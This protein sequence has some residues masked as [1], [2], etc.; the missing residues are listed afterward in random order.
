MQIPPFTIT[1]TILNLMVKISEKIGQLQ[2]AYVQ[3][4]HLR[5]NN[6]LRSIQASLAIENNS[7]SL[8]QVTDIINGRKVLGKPKEIQ[9]VKNAFDAYEI[10]PHLSPYRVED[11][12]QSHHLMMQGLVD[13]AGQFRTGDVGIF[14][15]QGK[16]MHL[17]ARP[18]FVPRLIADLFAWAEQ[19]STPA[20]IKSCVM[21]YEIEVI[22]PF[23]DGNGRMGRLWQTLVLSADTPVFAWLPIETMVYQHQADYY[24]TLAQADT[25]N[26][27][28][29][30][31]E[32]Y[33]V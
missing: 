1:N 32:R 9:E 6:R 12:L 4:L 7:M 20:L 19:D 31:N 29:R 24:A 3:N 25:H 23:A 14:N 30:Y 10:I 11:F 5:K 28:T 13:N 8:E 26:D 16:V 18:E 22:H 27:S 33:I 21:H 15:T 17:G 2:V